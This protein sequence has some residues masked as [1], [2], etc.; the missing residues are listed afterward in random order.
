M[1]CIKMKQIPVW[2]RGTWQMEGPLS[3]FPEHIISQRTLHLGT[4]G[5]IL[6]IR[7]WAR[8]ATLP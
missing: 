4:L 3:D 6:G 2:E 5:F 1:Q 8:A 7:F